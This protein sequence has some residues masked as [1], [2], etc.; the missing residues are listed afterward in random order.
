MFQK[1]WRD[2]MVNS[3]SPE[4]DRL[5]GGEEITIIP[6]MQAPNKPPVLDRAKAKTLMVIFHWPSKVAL[7]RDNVPVVSRAPEIRIGYYQLGSFKIKARDV[8]EVPR[9]GE[10][11]QVSKVE[12]DGVSSVRLTL[13]QIGLQPGSK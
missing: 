5:L 6:T 13:T 9:T 8:I 7:T 4:I 11:F 2:M 1:D 3:V 12:P 10:T